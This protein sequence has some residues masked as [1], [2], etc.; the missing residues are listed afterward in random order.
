[1]HLERALLESYFI[2]LSWCVTCKSLSIH[3]GIE[4][5]HSE[6][7]FCSICSCHLSSLLAEKLQLL[8]VFPWNSSAA[9]M[10]TE[11]DIHAPQPRVWIQ[12]LKLFEDLTGW[13]DISNQA[14]NP[15]QVTSKT[16]PS[17]VASQSHRLSSGR[18]TSPANRCMCWHWQGPL[19]PC[20][21]NTWNVRIERSLPFFRY[22]I[23]CH[24]LWIL[25]VE[26]WYHFWKYNRVDW[27]LLLLYNLIFISLPQVP[28][29]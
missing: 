1:M 13:V 3:P 5:F 27:S 17:K 21:G 23:R 2:L 22:F 18:Q 12:V 26:K 15:G 29:C 24:N 4:Q 9:V 6:V 7:F 16:V 14:P 11:Y 10:L 19:H 28:V 25:T 20:R 8:K